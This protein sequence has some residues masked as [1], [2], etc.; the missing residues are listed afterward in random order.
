[1]TNDNSDL[2]ELLEPPQAP[3]APEPVV[4]VLQ[5]EEEWQVGRSSSEVSALIN[6]IGTAKLYVVC[7]A[8]G[9]CKGIFL[10]ELVANEA[11]IFYSATVSEQV[12]QNK[13]PEEV[14]ENEN[15]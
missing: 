4:Q 2:P 5:P 6:L 7:D 12:I 15:A 3:A 1:M 8:N 9:E 10:D 11:A 14:Q 13:L